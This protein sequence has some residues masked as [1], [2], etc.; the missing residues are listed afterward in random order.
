MEAEEDNVVSQDQELIILLIIY[1]IITRKQKVV[2]F[3]SVYLCSWDQ[4]CHN[5][6][7]QNE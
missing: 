6:I 4:E 5:Y 7:K 2:S 1:F 3:Y